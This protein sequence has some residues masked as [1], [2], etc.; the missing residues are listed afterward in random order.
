MYRFG[1][2]GL[3]VLQRDVVHGNGLISDGN[4]RR[5]R[6]ARNRDQEQYQKGGTREL[7]LPYSTQSLSFCLSGRGPSF[8]TIGSGTSSF[9][10]M[11]VYPPAVNARLV[12]PARAGRAAG[13][14]GVGTAVSFDCGS[15]A[16][17]SLA[18]VDDDR[19]ITEAR[20]QTNG[21]G[22]MTA[23]AGVVAE[24]LTGRPLTELHSADAVE[25]EGRIQAELGPFPP[26]RRQC[27]A[28][29]LEALRLALADYRAYAIE[30]FS[31]EKA[32]ICTCFGIAE[33]T[34]L[35]Y[36]EAKMP[37]TVAE[38]SAAC[39]AGGGCGSCRRLIQE[40][41]DEQALSR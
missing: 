5:R 37:E 39:R 18:V 14:N 7:H 21:C 25:L 11:S 28:V 23:A 38:V 36:I 3:S 34:I 4:R 26:G 20:F 17:I 6:A 8:F 12:S 33:E 9:D 16:R 40:M 31:G 30:E 24:Y 13:A 29:V 1:R 2:P 19:T 10:L 27:T 32:L 15:F 22:F 41:I 35:A